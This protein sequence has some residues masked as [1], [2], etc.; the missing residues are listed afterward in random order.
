[1]TA[2]VGCCRP[3]PTPYLP[4][5]VSSAWRAPAK[6]SH[7]EGLPGRDSTPASRTRPC[8]RTPHRTAAW[9][10]RRRPC[11]RPGHRL[12]DAVGHVALQVLAQVRVRGRRGSPAAAKPDDVGRLVVDDVGRG[13]ALE[14]GDQLVVD[15]VPAAL[16][17][18]HLDVGV[19]RVPGVDDLL[20]RRRSSCPG[21]RS[22][23]N[24][25]LTFSPGRRHRRRPPKPEQPVSSEGQC[26]DAGDGDCLRVRMVFPLG[27]Y[28]GAGSCRVEG[29]A[30][31]R[32]ARSPAG[33]PSLDER[34]KTRLGMRGEERG[35]GELAELDLALGA[36]EARERERQGLQC[37]VLDEHEREEELVPGGDE[38]EQA[39]G[40]Q[41]RGEQRAGRSS[42]ACA[43][44][45]RRRSR[46]PPRVRRG[47]AA[48]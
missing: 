33:E 37:R 26:Q 16:H 11:R 31:D 44:A 29:S 30:L 6:S 2:A 18:L 38:R 36:D 32:A 24:V 35:R 20:G 3:Q 28:G 17:E 12:P 34:K 21:T 1:M 47:I 19:G 27:V 42:R 41:A 5:A 10:G 14:L 4:S 9:S 39:G 22:D 8:W 13:A 25:S 7:V 23:W 40:D 43:D 15:V 48:T 45:R 46:P